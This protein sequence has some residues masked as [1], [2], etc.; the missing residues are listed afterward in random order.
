MCPAGALS[1]MITWSFSTGSRGFPCLTCL[2]RSICSAFAA[3]QWLWD[4]PVFVSS[5]CVFGFKKKKFNRVLFFFPH[6]SPTFC[7]LLCTFNNPTS[8]PASFIFFSVW[9]WDTNAEAKVKQEPELRWEIAEL[10]VYEAAL[11]VSPKV[12]NISTCNEWLKVQ[13]EHC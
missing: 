7:C 3:K 9:G 1:H 4:V 12:V 11:F 2:L 5:F 10:W 13:L 8:F 6:A